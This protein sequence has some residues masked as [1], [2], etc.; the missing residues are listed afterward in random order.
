MISGYGVDY[1]VA[2]ARMLR[3]DEGRFADFLIVLLQSLERSGAG[4]P[5]IRYVKDEIA[6]VPATEISAP[7]MLARQCESA[8]HLLDREA[9]RLRDGGNLVD[10]WK[11]ARAAEEV[12]DGATVLLAPVTCKDLWFDPPYYSIGACLCVI[13]GAAV[14]ARGFTMM[15]S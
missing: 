3:S 4:I 9:Q 6:S 10:A 12:L 1:L 13:A 14:M 2:Q 5:A 15:P 11:Q 8:N 7:G